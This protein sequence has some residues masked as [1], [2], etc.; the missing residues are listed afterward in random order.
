MDAVKVSV[1]TAL[2]SLFSKSRNAKRDNTQHP[3]EVVKEAEKYV[4]Q[5]FLVEP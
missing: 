3:L 2:T 4:V 5:S 1:S